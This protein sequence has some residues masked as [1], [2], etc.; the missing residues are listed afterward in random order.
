MEP[1]KN[2]V[3]PRKKNHWLQII[4]YTS[5]LFFTLSLPFLDIKHIPSISFMV[6]LLCIFGG[7]FYCG[8]MCP[9]GFFQDLTTLIAK[10]FKIKQKAIPRKLHLILSPLRYLIFLGM[11]MGVVWVSTA[12]FMGDA[13]DVITGLIE[14]KIPAIIGIVSFTVFIILSIFYKRVFCSYFCS[15]GAKFGLQGFAKIFTIKRDESTCI[16][17]KKCD[18]VCPMNI[19]VSTSHNLQSLQC[20]NC[21]QCISACPVSKTLSYGLIKAEHDP[22]GAK[23]NAQSPTKKYL[24]YLVRIILVASLFMYHFNAKSKKQ[25]S[26]QHPVVEV[27]EQTSK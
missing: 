4:R 15:L 19:D 24:I 26:E 16:S 21:F 17:C 11:I 23:I 5:L 27:V 10:K 8:W 3:K 14:G 20:V 9:M 7:P 25:E 22:L 2:S 6:L 12:I 1:S 13:R 18:K